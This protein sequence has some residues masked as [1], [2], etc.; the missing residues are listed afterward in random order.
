ML[1]TH[2][3]VRGTRTIG[4]LVAAF[5]ALLGACGDSAAPLITGGTEGDRTPPAVAVVADNTAS[6]PDSIVSV[7][8]TA[9]DN[10]GLRRVRVSATQRLPAGRDTTFVG[11]DTVFSSAV[12]DFSRVVSFRVP[13]GTP[14]GTQVTVSGGATDG[15]GNSSNDASIRV[16]TGNVQPPRVSLTAP[17]PG[18]LFVIGKSGTIAISASSRLKVRLVGYTASGAFTAADSTVFREPLRDSVSVLDTLTVPANAQNGVVTLVPFVVDSLGQ[19]AIGAPVSF[20]VQPITAV[21]ST[22]V[23]RSGVTRRVETQDTVRVSASDPTGIRVLGYEVV[24]TA[25][26][27]VIVADSAILSGQL[28]VAETTFTF[29]LP[30]TSFPTALY[31]RAFATNMAQRRAY[32]KLA[33]GTDRVDSVLVV[34]GLTR[35]LPNGGL[36]ADGIYAPRHDR[37]YLTNID[38][39]QLEIFNLARQ[40]FERAVVVGSRPWGIVGWPRNR[41]G[42]IGD[43]LLV[44]NSG[45]TNISYVRLGGDGSGAEVFRYPLPNILAYSITTELSSTTGL[46]IQT[47]KVYDFSDRPQFLAATCENRSTGTDACGEVKLVYST[48]PTPGQSGPFPKRGTVRWESLTTCTSHFF[49]EPGVGTDDRRADTLEIVRFA[50]DPSYRLP[51]SCEQPADSTVLV[52]YQQTVTADDGSEAI[53]STTV[54][55]ERLGFRDTTF[56]RNSGNFARAIIGEGGSVLGSRAIGYDANRGMRTSFERLGRT[57]RF[58]TPVTDLGVSPARDVSDF[59]ANTFSRVLGVAVNFDGAL[60]AIRGDSTYIIDPQ[61]RLQGL[62]PTSGGPNAGFDFHPLNATSGVVTADVSLRLAFSASMAPQIEVFD[63]YCYQKLG[64]IETRDPMVGPIKASVRPNGQI[65]LVGASAR[66]VVVIPLNRTFTS[67]CTPSIRR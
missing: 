62:L 33:S 63:T 3:P 13:L 24:D 28:T 53:Y 1:T 23:V 37:L 52:P 18:S 59:I 20:A 2:P 5:A 27:R 55:V 48:T 50:A 51:R 22:P 21:N 42:A 65:V 41:M 19:R 64:A 61:L 6:A 46:A 26:R 30:V 38:R 14:A 39:N 29:R 32:T 67:G 34:A 31:V 49:F 57:W 44:A 56:V 25:T 66:G 10:L 11:L 15:A 7:R 43:T 58:E 16:A 47:R 36:V 4:A 12:T 9:R 45:G 17:L 35:P 54:Q 40:S 8:V 60:S